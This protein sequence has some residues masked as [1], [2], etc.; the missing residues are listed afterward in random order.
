MRIITYPFLDIKW[1]EDKLFNDINYNFH[2]LL[3]QHEI[4]STYIYE[5]TLDITHKA[6]SYEQ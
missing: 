2:I 5:V 3:T 1:Q 4:T 6:T